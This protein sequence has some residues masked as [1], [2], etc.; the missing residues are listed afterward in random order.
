[1]IYENLYHQALIQPFQD[2]ADQLKIV[3]GYA[4]SA[5]AF[6]HLQEIK[7][8]R[9]N[10]N[11]SLL[12][13]MCPSDGISI[14][15][16]RGFQKLMSADYKN[17]F[18]C[19]YIF[20]KPPVHSKIYIWSKDEKPFKCFIGSANYTQMA[21]SSKQRECL[22]D[23]TDSNVLHYFD[24]L[25]RESIFCDHPDTEGL[26]TIYNDKHYYRKHTREDIIS[27]STTVNEAV[28]EE[29]GCEK[30][31]V[32]LLG[33]NGEMQNRGGLNWGQRD[34]RDHNQAYIQLPPEVY[35]SDFFPTR[36]I[37]F[38]IQTDDNKQLMCTRAQKSEEG[39]AIETPQ[40]NSLIGEY[41]RHRLGLS[42]GAFVTKQHLEKYGRTNV[43]FYK[44]DDENYYMDFS[45]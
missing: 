17:D 19:S 38:T 35:R 41:F 30:I 31:V 5:M 40:N 11:V 42:S 15:N 18:R 6:H 23:I 14:S 44:F 21:F 13:G 12:V 24:L 43:A 2:G 29:I 16:H 3:S 10:L 26:I 39:Q 37:H 9:D 1:M 32:S 7:E 27:P 22:T 20:N 33:R 45:I 4:T 34:G 25:E 36:S 28:P 8:I